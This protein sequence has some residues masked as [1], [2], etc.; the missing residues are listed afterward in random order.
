MQVSKFVSKF[1]HCHNLRIGKEAAKF[2]SIRL[3]EISGMY[4]WENNKKE[5]FGDERWESSAHMDK[6][7]DREKYQSFRAVKC[8]SQNNHPP[9]I[10]RP[11]GKYLA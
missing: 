7:V 4:N 10:L 5:K 6:V 1:G 2:R 9:Q 11:I 3:A 8:L